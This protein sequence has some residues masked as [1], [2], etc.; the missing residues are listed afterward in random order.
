LQVR[1][2]LL[3]KDIASL[4]ALL[5]LVREATA[6]PPRRYAII[7]EAARIRYA[8]QLPEVEPRESLLARLHALH[9]DFA[10]GIGSD[11]VVTAI[12]EA[13]ESYDLAELTRAFL[14]HYITAERREKSSLPPELAR[15]LTA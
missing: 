4:P 12:C 3:D 1:R 8:L 5:K 15:F 6:E 14:K 13:Y 9:A 11:Y 7:S 2:A 10:L